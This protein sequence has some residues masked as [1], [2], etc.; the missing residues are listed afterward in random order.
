[1][2]VSGSSVQPRSIESIHTTLNL[3]FPISIVKK[4]VYLT[5]LVVFLGLHSIFTQNLHL[6]TIK[7][8]TNKK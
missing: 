5:I 3:M 4:V 7:L 6:L 2:V 8:L 1:M